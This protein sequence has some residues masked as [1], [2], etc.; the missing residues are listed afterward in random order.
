MNIKPAK[1]NVLTLLAI[2]VSLSLAIPASALDIFMTSTDSG[3]AFRTMDG[4]DLAVE[5]HAT[6]SLPGV[7]A[8]AIGDVDTTEEGD[9]IVVGRNGTL[10]IYD[11]DG[12]ALLNSRAG[13]NQINS[14]AIGDVLDASAGNEIVV[15]ITTAG[16]AG[17]LHVLGTSSA[18]LPTVRGTGA[19]LQVSAVAIGD[20]VSAHA[21]NEIV[22]CWEYA[23]GEEQVAVYSTQEPPGLGF[24][25]H[26]IQNFVGV[27]EDSIAIGDIK[28]AS[29]QEEI[30]VGFN[31]G[32][33]RTFNAEA[34][35][36]GGNTLL[37]VMTQERAGFGDVTAVAVGDM[38]TNDG[39]EVVVGST[40]SSGAV[41]VMDGDDIT[42]D[43]QTRS[44]FVLIRDI[45]VGDV[46]ANTGNE[47]V[48]AS[49][50]GG[51]SL[52]VMDDDGA[53]TDLLGRGPFVE[54]TGLELIEM[55]LNVK[56]W[57]FY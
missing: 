44:G 48:V 31:N 7:T 9:E 50:D 56:E 55:P 26:K 53:L 41:R 38:D 14:I 17:E 23:N 32:A 52:R 16:S 25:T 34:T 42:T 40:D 21:G 18:A 49:D 13:F 27:C 4:D 30:V 51:G 33:L 37:L 54:T 28:A 10:E 3:G 11:K 20:M 47:A 6:G 43:L 15:G 35:D 39:L 46:N 45:A 36:P 8:V 1:L 12:Y 22:F 19:G 24:D 2:A 5:I 29:P 57:S